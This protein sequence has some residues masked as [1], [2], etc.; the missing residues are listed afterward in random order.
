MADIL[1]PLRS[2]GHG[3][4][5]IRSSHKH[6]NRGKIQIRA[7]YNGDAGVISSTVTSVDDATAAAAIVDALGVV[8]PKSGRSAVRPRP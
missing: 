6:A 7:T 8:D 1:G 4:R 3:L 2:P 5:L